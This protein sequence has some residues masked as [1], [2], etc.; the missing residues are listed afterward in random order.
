[1]RTQGIQT[2]STEEV[3]YVRNRPL[4]E[5]IASLKETRAG[6]SLSSLSLSPSSQAYQNAFFFESPDFWLNQG[7]EGENFLISREKATLGN[8]EKKDI[9]APSPPASNVPLPLP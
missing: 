3:S 7:K 2:Q 6:P 5:G 9:Q 1:M 4:N 8:C